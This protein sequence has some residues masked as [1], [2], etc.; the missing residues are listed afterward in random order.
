MYTIILFYD[1]IEINAT[2]YLFYRIT[3][4]FNLKTIAFSFA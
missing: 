3:V 2:F 1:F 4:R